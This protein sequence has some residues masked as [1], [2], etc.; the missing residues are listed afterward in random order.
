L[1]SACATTGALG[2]DP[3]TSQHAR[4]ELVPPAG[5][6]T[7]QVFPKA[8]EP[9]LP[10]ADRLGRAIEVRFGDQASVDVHLCVTPAGQVSSAELRRGST[11][12]L[13][14][15]A[16]LSDVRDWQFAVQPGPAS[17]KSCE[18]ATIVYRTH[19]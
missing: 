6:D 10:S 19:R 5:D 16:V 12:D 3:Q 14:D 15:Q 2:I 7:A 9:E 18:I 1:V 8:I 17:M 13:F 11:M 4:V